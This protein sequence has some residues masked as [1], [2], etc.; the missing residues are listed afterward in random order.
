MIANPAETDVF[1]DYGA[2]LNAL[3]P[4]AQGF[5][6]HDRHGRLFWS[7]NPPDGSLL[8]DEYHATL[9][10]LLQHGD[11]PGE[12]AK[13]PLKDCTAFLIRVLTDKGKLLGVVTALAD[14]E[15]AGM[16]YQ[17]CADLLAPATRSLSRELSLRMH[18]LGATR[19]LKNHGGEHNFL[20]ALA[21]KVHK[22]GRW[23]DAIHNVLVLCMEQFSLD[24]AMFLMPERN[25]RVVAGS[26]PADNAEVELWFESMQDL[27]AE[28]GGN[29][30]DTLAKRQ[31]PDAR[32]R[33]RSWPILQ[34]GHLA[35]IMA[36]SR[37]GKAP[38]WSTHTVALI[39]FAVSTIEHV[40]ERNFDPL[41]GLI[42][43]PG[44]ETAL[45]AACGDLE[46]QYTL[47]YLDVDQMH[48]VNDTFG[49]D[50]GDEILHR[51]ADI[52]NDKLDGHMITRVTSASFAVLLKS[53]ELDAAE[54]LG[55]EVCKALKELD[56]SSGGQI[57]RPSVSI[58][59][60]Q[61]VPTED[62]FRNVLA[63]A[64]IACQ[65]AKDRGRGRVEV[66]MAS[67]DSI[68]RRMDDLNQV[69]SIRGAI[70]AGRLVLF[71]QPIVRLGGADDIANYELLVRML[72]TADEPV[73]PAEFL[74]AAERYHLMQE[75]D[76]WVV[77][78]AIESLVAKPKAIDG[79]VLQ[80]A[81]NLSG[82]SIGNEQ[83]LDFLSGEL[84]RTGVKTERLCFEIT[85]TVAVANLKKAQNFMNVLKE[86]GC[87]F[88]LDDF[89]TGL[90][91]FAYL[92][93][94]PVDKLKIDG[95]FVQD[96]CKNDVSRSM[97]SAIAE[98]ARVMGLE[99]V[100][101]YVEDESTLK[102]IREMGVNWAQGYHV[103]EPMRLSYVLGESTIV[104]EVDIA[105]VDTS[106]IAKL[107]V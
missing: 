107:P 88:S 53:V 19:K 6:F 57:F 13:I 41:T 76:R 50:T 17:F 61:L 34:E 40:L 54:E 35:R 51:F 60:A 69:G 16:P 5:M 97:V 8:T 42:N 92:K 29:A 37:P 82:Q 21:G 64:Q 104:D 39:E 23:E 68:V 56:Y 59:V 85:E 26:R 28:S 2:F 105:E 91:S 27:V 24:G 14:R 78:K 65:A 79:R 11:L 32:A 33:S 98:I 4:Q 75:L 45:D 77:N 36:L 95:S 101:E 7:N 99:T 9:A 46:D 83:F 86:K 63:P 81:V 84:D 10:R 102:A 71:A 96:V 67:D 49:R 38:I 47:M 103:G 25:Q 43:W 87:H 3:L 20:S 31:P 18:L 74:G 22:S 48:V 44:F 30:A 93:M 15:M 80:F 12:Q 58:G 1:A 90:S 94:F 52:L 106:M 66:Y 100:A 62:G 72:N 55:K 73:E 70:E 89:G